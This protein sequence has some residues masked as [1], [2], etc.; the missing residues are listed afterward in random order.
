MYRM[1]IN[2]PTPNKMQSQLRTVMEVGRL[3][4]I[5]LLSRAIR[6]GRADSTRGN[7][8]CEERKAACDAPLSL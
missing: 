7:S 5:S 3:F 6:I 4:T 2:P 1:A 8:R